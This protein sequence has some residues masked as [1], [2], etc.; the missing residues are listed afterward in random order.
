MTQKTRV[1]QNDI[2]ITRTCHEFCGT[3]RTPN[4][5]RKNPRPS[6]FELGMK[7]NMEKGFRP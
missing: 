3:L 6:A 5:D 4:P 7:I 1:T 2:Q